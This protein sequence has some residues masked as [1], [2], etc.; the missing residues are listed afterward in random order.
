MGFYLPHTT[1]SLS[2]VIGYRDSGLPQNSEQFLGP[3]DVLMRKIHIYTRYM[4][5]ASVL[6]LIK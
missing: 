6:I 1:A 2:I 4:E 3:F 5:Q